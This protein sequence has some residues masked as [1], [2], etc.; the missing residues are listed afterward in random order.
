[1]SELIVQ[2]C[3]GSYERRPDSSRQTLPKD[4]LSIRQMFSNSI[5]IIVRK[6]VLATETFKTLI[7]L[8]G[9]DETKLFDQFRSQETQQADGLLP[10]FEQVDEENEG[11]QPPASEKHKRGA[12]AKMREAVKKA[13]ELSTKIKDIRDELN[14]LRATSQ[15]Q[16]DVQE[17]MYLGHSGGKEMSLGARDMRRLLG[18]DLSGEHVVNDITEMDVVANRIQEAVSML[19]REEGLH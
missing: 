9:R 15:Y 11:Q 10:Q 1:M 2:Y 18:S 13:E 16:K 4:L 12:D 17:R 6:R 19:I 14:I 7:I 8:Q 3:I 5:N